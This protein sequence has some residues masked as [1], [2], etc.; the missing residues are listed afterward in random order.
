MTSKDFRRIALGL[1]DVLE[2]AHMGHPDFR[3]GGRI[4]ATL[5]ADDRQGMVTLTPEQQDAVIRADPAVFAPASGA[6]GRQ[7]CTVVQ[8]AS[9]DA[10]AV[11][12]AMTLAWQNAVT[13][14]VLKKKP[15]AKGVRKRKAAK[16]AR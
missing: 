7:G 2:N 13:L 3:V 4:F 10:D 11:G 8:L 12:D 1:Q 6:W 16:G 5:S 15:A 14:N 9:A